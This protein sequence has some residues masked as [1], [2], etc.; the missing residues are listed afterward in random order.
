MEPGSRLMMC[1]R[2]AVPISPCTMASRTRTK[3][4]SNRRLNPTCS[5]TPAFFTS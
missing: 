4:A 1:I 5:L 3:L 2:C